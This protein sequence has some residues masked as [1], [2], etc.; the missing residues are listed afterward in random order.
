[1][2]RSS[3]SEERDGLAL[4]PTEPLRIA[5]GTT[6]PPGTFEHDALLLALRRTSTRQFKPTGTS[7]VVFRTRLRSEHSLA[8]K[9]RTRTHRDG[10]QREIAA[11]RIGRLLGLDNVP[12]ATARSLPIWEIR[13]RMHPDFVDVEA[14]GELLARLVPEPTEQVPGAAIY[15][16]PGLTDLGLDRGRALA[17]WRAWLSQ[18]GPSCPEDKR[19]L[20]RDL[21]NMLAF[22]YLVANWDRFSG[23]NVQGIETEAGPRVVIR[24][25]DVTLA[26]GLPRELHARILERLGWTERFSRGL[27]DALR[28]LDRATLDAAFADE[29]AAAPLLSDM[30]VDQLFER[31][32]TLLS[33]VGALTDR[34]GEDAVLVFD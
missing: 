26:S 12:P 5:S 13:D 25:H 28:R 4:A 3:R 1:M 16:V 9:P 2:G 29:S 23:G 24:D 11:Y 22:D 19:A 18:D 33:Y 20:C 17:E 15:W 8:F 21:S 32:A 7:A 10:W 30:A 34:Y 31:R 6:F 27:V 14:R